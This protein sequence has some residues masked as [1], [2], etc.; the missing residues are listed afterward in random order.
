MKHPPPASPMQPLDGA[1]RQAGPFLRSLLQALREPVLVL[2]LGLRVVMA[3][4]AFLEQFNLSEQQ[5]RHCPVFELGGG[6]WN[7][8]ALRRLLQE[9]VLDHEGL[10]D[11][12][13]TQMVGDELRLLHLNARRLHRRPG[14]VELL[15]L[16]FE[17]VTARQRLQAELERANDELGVLQRAQLSTRAVAA[18][19]SL[20]LTASERLDAV[21]SDQWKAEHHQRRSGDR[22]A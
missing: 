5:T 8:P 17:D 20:S 18:D 21:F 7:T 13:M 12:E 14:K 16:A 10:R 11:L 1:R 22:R 9:V 19:S 15:L 2:D 6:E 4:R 3:N